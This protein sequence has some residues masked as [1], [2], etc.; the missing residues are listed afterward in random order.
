MERMKELVQQL[1]KYNYEYYTLDNPTISDKEW[2]KLYNELLSLEKETDII[3]PDSPTQKIGGD[4]LKGFEKVH[5]EKK[6]WSLDK[7]Q[8]IEEIEEWVNSCF[9]FVKEYNRTHEE[10]LPLPSFLVQKK[11][12]GL[13]IKCHYNEEGFMTQGST[14][15]TGVEGE[16]V[17]EQI[18]TALNLPLKLKN[19]E[20]NYWFDFHGEGLMTKKALQEYND[21][22]P[23]KPD[24][25]LKNCRNGIAGAIRNLDPKETAKRKPI[26]YFYNINNTNKQFTSYKGQIDYI[27]KLGLPTA[28]YEICNNFKEVKKA[29]DKIE[30]QRESLPFDI[31]GAVI[32]IN[33]LR[34]REL[35]GYTAK[36]P[37]FSMAYKYEAL[38]ET[39]ILIDVI[40][41]TGRTGKVTPTAIVSPVKIG[42]STIT[43]ATLNNVNDIK[44]KG[45]KIGAEI[46]LRKSND[47]IPEITGTITESLN[48]RDIEEIEIPTLC[49]SCQKPLENVN[50]TLY[51]RNDLCPAQSLKAISHYCSRKAMDIR[52]L[53]EKTLEM[54]MSK[55]YIKDIKDIYYLAKEDCS[56][57][58]EIVHIKGF[59]KKSY[60]NLVKAINDSKNC[61][62]SSF[63]YALGIPNVGEQ[64]AKDLVDFAKKDTAKET[65]KNLI[66]ME[67][68]ELLRIPN[69]GDVLASSVADWFLE[70]E[71]IELINYLVTN[72]LTFLDDEKPTVSNSESIS[73][74]FTGKKI[75]C[76][77][78]FECGK[79]N[80]LIRMVE[81]AGGVFANGYAKSLDYL[82]VGKKKGSTKVDMA[83]EDGI[84]VLTEDEFLEMINNS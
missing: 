83:L 73:N 14:R 48:K 32:A 11:F 41:N 42:G 30:E 23:K 8:K 77:G 1:N 9:A 70:D 68:Q 80:E 59:G 22:Y 44:R 63:I 76:T 43:K 49:P 55:G 40:W 28:K 60:D 67:R 34:T 2:D 19:K 46:F 27:Q 21:K 25:F 51:C 71:N 35:M 31:D 38:E 84:S 20:D 26:I 50:G 45:V 74:I 79:K 57:K 64:T 36:F 81:N 6:L 78:S 39:T 33:D 62:L 15:G 52:G 5:H 12:D 10:Q 7:R 47:V 69:C 37:K 53:S 16:L 65:L 54:F 29:I 56:Y 66:F 75:Y 3:L 13:T 61:K 4:I 72:E 58:D 17:T 24:D 18:K 82:V